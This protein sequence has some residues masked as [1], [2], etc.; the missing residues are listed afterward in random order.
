MLA[1][2]AALLLPA[3]ASPAFSP[4][5]L[6]AGRGA[7]PP[8]YLAWYQGAARTCPGL[9]REVLAGIGTMESDNGPPGAA[10]PGPGGAP[11]VR[12]G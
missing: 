10:G 11:G 3:T 8:R 5:A 7:I 6:V 9:R 12:I 4:R 1:A 2:T